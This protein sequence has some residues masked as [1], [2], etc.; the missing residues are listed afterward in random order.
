MDARANIAKTADQLNE[1]FHYWA[2]YLASNKAYDNQINSLPE[3]GAEKTA[4]LAIAKKTLAHLINLAK[5][6]SIDDLPIDDFMFGIDKRLRQIEH[7][8]ENSPLL[9]RKPSTFQTDEYREMEEHLSYEW[10]CLQGALTL[11]NILQ[12]AN[13]A[14]IDN[15]R[16]VTAPVATQQIAAKKPVTPIAK[17]RAILSPWQQAISTMGNDEVVA[18]KKNLVKAN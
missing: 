17:I 10:T 4:I 2:T 14:K 5:K 1:E 9:I 6:Q 8:L 13:K 15:D 18:P 12:E 16:T 7:A 3:F 11:E